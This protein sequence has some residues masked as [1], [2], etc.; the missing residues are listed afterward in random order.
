MKSSRRIKPWAI[1]LLAW[2]LPVFAQVPGR[3]VVERY[4]AESLEH[5]LHLSLL[6]PLERSIYSTVVTGFAHTPNRDHLHPSLERFFHRVLDNQAVDFYELRFELVDR[7]TGESRYTIACQVTD[8]Q[9]RH[10]F[11]ISNCVT[12][13][14]FHKP[15]SDSDTRDMPFYLAHLRP[16]APWFFFYSEVRFQSP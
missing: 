8:W 13:N 11:D 12:R 2:G 5:A 4:T 16:D 3:G 9:S 15:L 1:L 6:R 7:S 10:Y 14:G